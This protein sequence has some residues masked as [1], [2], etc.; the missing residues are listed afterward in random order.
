MTHSLLTG[1]SRI[2]RG[3]PFLEEGPGGEEAEI[4]NDPIEER[5]FD[6]DVCRGV[7]LRGEPAVPLEEQLLA[8]TLALC[9]SQKHWFLGE[10]GGEPGTTQMVYDVCS[11]LMYAAEQGWLGGK[12]ACLSTAEAEHLLAISTLASFADSDLAFETID[13]VF[14]AA[15]RLPTAELI[16]KQLHRGLPSRGETAGRLL[17]VLAGEG[18]VPAYEDY[19]WVDVAVIDMAGCALKAVLADKR[20]GPETN[21]LVFHVIYSLLERHP[22]PRPS[23]VGTGW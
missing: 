15:G 7:G 1:L 14:K 12:D 13:K 9:R 3:E 5:H 20:S 22:P 18:K 23:T 8:Q 11:G 6:F 17:Q 21:D 16:C 10:D 2:G 19:T 4:N